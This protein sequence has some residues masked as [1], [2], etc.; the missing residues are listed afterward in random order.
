MGFLS[1]T[2]STP[3][4][5]VTA[6]PCAIRTDYCLT[7]TGTGTQCCLCWSCPFT[8][9]FLIQFSTNGNWLSHLYINLS[10]PLVVCPFVSVSVRIGVDR[11]ATRHFGSLLGKCYSVNINA[12][13][14][15]RKCTSHQTTYTWKKYD[16]VKISDFNDILKFQVEKF[17][18][19]KCAHCYPWWV[20]TGLSRARRFGR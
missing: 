4:L 12:L 17:F 2:N 11:S 9:F 3:T 5:H 14:L 19:D 1:T 18:R 6:L 20:A 8:H 13:S 7:G 10:D 16:S 15:W